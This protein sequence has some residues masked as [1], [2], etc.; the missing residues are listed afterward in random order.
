MTNFTNLL[1]AAAKALAVLSALVLLLLLVGR[2][3]FPI[4]PPLKL[5]LV[6][7]LGA[8]LL[9]GVI[10]VQFMAGALFDLFTFHHAKG[11]NKALR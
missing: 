1:A 2:H 9:V 10:A 5:L 11:G 7:G 4:I 6:A 3:L 8:L